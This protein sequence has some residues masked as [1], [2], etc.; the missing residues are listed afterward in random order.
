[1]VHPQVV[2][3]RDHEKGAS[4][5]FCCGF[6]FFFFFVVFFVFFCWIKS[7]MYITNKYRN[8]TISS[9]RSEETTRN[10]NSAV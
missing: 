1:M 10:W 3:R 5:V 9:F 8:T 2:V 4:F 7:C 6:F